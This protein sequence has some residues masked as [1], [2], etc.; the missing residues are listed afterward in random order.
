ML[1]IQLEVGFTLPVGHRGGF[2]I[3]PQTTP[4]V[5]QYGW[6]LNRTYASD[7]SGGELYLVQDI[8]GFPIHPQPLL[9][10]I[11]DLV[12]YW[13]LTPPLNIRVGY[14]L[15]DNFGPGKIL[16]WKVGTCVT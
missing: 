14:T 15:V 6:V 2:P 4:Y 1:L 13:G 11:L 9:Q 10:T 7:S 8:G 12:L 3:H 5:K 16:T